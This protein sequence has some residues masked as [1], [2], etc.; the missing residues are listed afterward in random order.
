[1]T[2]PPVESSSPKPPAPKKVNYKIVPFGA[3]VIA[4]PAHCALLHAELLPRSPLTK[5]GTGFMGRFY[6]KV[7]PKQGYIFGAIAYVDGNPAGFVAA[8]YDSD[9]FLRRAVRHN[10]FRLLLIGATTFPTPRR[11]EG[12]I[13]SLGIL[14][15]RGPQSQWK[16]EL[17]GEILSIGVRRAY[18]S[19]EFKITTG[20]EIAKDLMEGAMDGFRRSNL[21]RVRLIVDANDI[22]TQGFYSRLGWQPRRR[23]VPGWLTPSTE[24]VWS[25]K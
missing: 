12:G 5:L 8:T 17:T 23:S 13:E 11:I 10:L 24:F 14:Q 20:I 6:Y 1:M 9:G 21:N 19:S 2:A 25:P 4:N 7:L 15:A 22:Q 18:R 3:G 16:S